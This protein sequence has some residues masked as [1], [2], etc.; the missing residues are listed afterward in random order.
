MNQVLPPVT[1][2]DFE[3]LASRSATVIGRLRDRL[4]DSG[5]FL[6]VDGAFRFGSSGVAERALEPITTTARL[7]SIV[8]E[9]NPRWEK[10][11]HPATRAFQAL[12]IQVNRELGDLEDLLAAS[13]DLRPEYPP[14][15]A[16][17]VPEMSR[18]VRAGRDSATEARRAS[19]SGYWPERS[20]LWLR[21]RCL[22][23]GGKE[24]VNAR[25]VQRGEQLYRRKH[26][27][28]NSPRRVMRS[29]KLRK[30]VSG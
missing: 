5:G 3:T 21:S 2:Q 18:E 23:E 24:M 15:P 29:D 22:Q 25:K 10:H 6:G 19:A 16:R 20:S 14:L 11:K 13:L 8:S 28:G 17:L 26:F 27:S 7:A 1:M 9:A 12:R 4:Y 30:E